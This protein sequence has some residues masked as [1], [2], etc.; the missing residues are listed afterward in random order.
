MANSNPKQLVT[1]RCIPVNQPIGVFYIG[2]MEARDLVAISWADVRRI[3]PDENQPTAVA[4]GTDSPKNHWGGR[5][6]AGIS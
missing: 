5:P 2:A 4:D 1:F 3:A 6:D